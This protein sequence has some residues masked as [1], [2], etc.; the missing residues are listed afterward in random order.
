M[1][2]YFNSLEDTLSVEIRVYYAIIER[3]IKEQNMSGFK[4][5][6]VPKIKENIIKI[7]DAMEK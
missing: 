5:Q 7:I 1:N 2:K 6:T 4:E 3:F